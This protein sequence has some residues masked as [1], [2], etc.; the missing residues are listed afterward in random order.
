MLGTITLL[1]ED[2]RERFARRALS[3]AH[4]FLRVTPKNC[5][6]DLRPSGAP[7][8]CFAAE[9]PPTNHP[10]A[11]PTPRARAASMILS[12]RSPLHRPPAPRAPRPSPALCLERRPP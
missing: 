3:S 10:M 11:E 4:I 2:L 1:V 5:G 7:R 12:H 8:R 9:T 6:P